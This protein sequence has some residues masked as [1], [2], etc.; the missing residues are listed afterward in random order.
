M[1]SCGLNGIDVLP[2]HHAHLCP[3]PIEMPSGPRSRKAVISHTVNAARGR[4]AM[5][6]AVLAWIAISGTISVVFLGHSGVGVTQIL[7]H[8]HQRRAIHDGVT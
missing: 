6:K 5:A 2:V 7:R 4:A 8:H 1:S 3:E